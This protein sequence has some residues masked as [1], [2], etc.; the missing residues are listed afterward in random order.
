MRCIALPTVI[1]IQFSL[2]ASHSW[3]E[4]LR[5][6]SSNGAYIGDP[7][8][9]RGNVLRTSP[10][11]SDVPMVHMIGPT[12]KPTDQMC[13]PTQQNAVQT[14]GSPRLKAPVGSFIALQFQ[15]NGH[16]TL[17]NGQ[18][19]KPPNRG[20]VFIYGTSNPQPN[21]NFSAIHNVW[22]TDGT[23]GDKR[24]KLLATQNY[25]DG[26]CY[27][28]NGGPISGSRKVEFSKPADKLQGAD[29]WCQNDIALP[30]DISV[31]KPYTLYWVWDWPTA[32]GVDPGLPQGKVETYTTCMDIDIVTGEPSQKV[33]V[34][35]AQPSL[36]NAAVPKLFESLKSSGS[37]QTPQSSQPPQ[38]SEPPK[39][40][41]KSQAP[42]A[43]RSSQPPQASQP[44]PQDH[45]PGVKTIYQTVYV[46]GSTP[47]PSPK[48]RA[49]EFKG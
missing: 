47:T 46:N 28:I 22:N 44:P 45:A 16:V 11:F 38:A 25:D 7:G 8:F 48:R 37:P 15:E 19:G 4:Q 13:G 6:I 35:D 12:V 41:T 40:S 23:G 39:A 30:Q 34:P 26:Q 20:S 42:K 33:V 43:P 17:P 24:G 3:V 9:V 2:A 1:A 49:V 32:P 27:Q 18:L 21:E 29:L 10:G 31:G 14:D 5:L 36:G